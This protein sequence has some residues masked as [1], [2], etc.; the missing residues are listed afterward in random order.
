M[1]DSAYGDGECPDI[2]GKFVNDAGK[3]VTVDQIGCF[4]EV[5]MYW[6]E[7]L[8]PVLK[9]GRVDARSIAQFQ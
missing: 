8:G 1:D 4:V 3:D 5:K 7:K 6:N 9:P 2:H